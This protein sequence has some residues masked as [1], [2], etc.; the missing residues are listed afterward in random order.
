MR[1]LT[2]I[3]VAALLTS[4]TASAGNLAITPTTTLAAE[5]ANNTSGADA[6]PAQSNNNPAPSNISK[7]P[8]R[9]LLYAES[10]TRIYAHF[11]PWFGGANHMWVGYRSDDRAQVGKQVS[12]MMSRGYDG[13]I[14]DWYGPDYARE[15]NT[16]LYLRDEA[17]T[18]GGLFTFAVMED[19][20]S[21]NKCAATAGCD[22]TQKLIN[23]LNYAASTYYP[24]PAYMRIGG[25]PVMFFFGVDKY[26]ID[27][28][29]AR[30]GVNGNPL[31]IFRQSSAFTHAQ[32]DGGFSWVGIGST[33]TDMGLGYLDGFYSTGLKYPAQQTFGSAYAGFNNTLAAWV[34]N[35]P[36]VVDRQCGQTW[37]ASLAEAGKY[38]SASKPLP[39]MQMV[40]WNDYEEGSELETGIESCA[41]VTAAVNG[42]VLSWTLSGDPS[43]VDHYNVYISAD[44]QNLMQLAQLGGGQTSLDVSSFALATGSY[45]LYVQAYAKASL[46]NAMSNVVTY[47]VANK[48]PA[49]TLALDATSGVAPQTITASST[50]TDADGNIAS[51]S[52]D[53]GDGSAPASAATAPHQYTVPGTYTVTATATDNDGGTGSATATVTIAA[54]QPPVAAL[55]LSPGSGTAPVTVTASTANSSDADGSVVSSTIDFGD[56]TVLAGPSAAH[57]YATAG[58]KTVTARVTDN[59]GA[60]SAT[61]GTVSVTAPANQ[62]PVAALNVTPTSGMAALSV[63]ASTAGS[64]DADGSIAA[65]KIDFGDGAVATTASATHVYA[66]VGMYTVRATVTD[67]QGASTTTAKSVSVTAGVKITSPLPGAASTSP[68]WVT[69]SAVSANPI[70]FMRVYVDN[71]SRY[72]VAA[73]SVNTSV[74]MT[75]GTHK[76]VVQ[77][78]DSAG[79]VYK[80]QVNITVK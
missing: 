71:V 47:A 18:R 56:G 15:N 17:E 57:A 54:N 8:V 27:W 44:G 52:I 58:T 12:D 59:K 23:D 1:T 33:A 20:G 49:V 3:M 64:S 80:A 6:F 45:Q 32:S 72:A 63:S 62:A 7:L 10:A 76:I 5:T 65:M 69:A 34:S 13:A 11:L 46:R 68:V 21:L 37:L 35:P 38:Y 66:R 55:S 25:R 36:K 39:Q 78:W 42:A 28:T 70:T 48:P 43:V 40:T 67:N 77:A 41:A 22:V 19:V 79:V 75:K 74:T 31:F 29:R 60:T 51:T 16:T 73:S 26:V 30:A 4:A 24:S 14:V 50:A 2:A 9:S 61:S 53:F